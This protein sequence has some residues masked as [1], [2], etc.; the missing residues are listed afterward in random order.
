MTEVILDAAHAIAL[1]SSTDQYHERA[2]TMAKQLETDGT[3]L[4]TT[5]AVLLEIGNALA[6]QRYRAAA[7]KLL[8]SLQEDPDV[9]IIPISE[10]LL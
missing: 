4:I 5:F 9:E 3:R 7:I 6:K 8:D 1:S 2:K 10:D